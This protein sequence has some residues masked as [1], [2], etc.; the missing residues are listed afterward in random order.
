M[1]FFLYKNLMTRKKK[2]WFWNLI[3]SSRSSKIDIHSKPIIQSPKTY[4]GGWEKLRFFGTLFLNK[5]IFSLILEV[6][7]SQSRSS[8]TVICRQWRIV[9]TRPSRR[10]WMT[11][12]STFHLSP[13]Y[14]IS[15]ALPH[16]PCS[17]ES[18]YRLL[19]AAIISPLC[20]SLSLVLRR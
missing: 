14:E 1:L 4:K 5:I 17:R 13:A 8:L 10:T 2:N 6:F 9:S 18:V 19:W 11:I 12:M 20:T 16:L 3:D 7:L 15:T